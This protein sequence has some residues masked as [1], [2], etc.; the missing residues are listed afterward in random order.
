M[1][2]R[3]EDNALCEHLE[4]ACDERDRLQFEICSLVDALKDLVSG[5]ERAAAAG[6]DLSGYVGTGRALELIARVEG[7]R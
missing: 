6:M 2:T 3:Q 5:I 1:M 4:R 7:R